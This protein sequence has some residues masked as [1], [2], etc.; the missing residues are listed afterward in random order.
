MIFGESITESFENAISAIV[1][2]WDGFW[3]TLE[4]FWDWLTKA[5]G[6]VFKTLE[7]GWKSIKRVATRV[8]K[9][10]W[11]K[12]EKVIDDVLKAWEG[13][14]TNLG[15]VF[16]NIWTA[17]KKLWDDIVDAAGKV[18]DRIKEAWGDVKKFF[19]D[20]FDGILEPVQTAMQ[21]VYDFVVGLWDDGKGGGIKGAWD[22][23]TGFFKGI[24]ESVKTT[25]LRIW[26][27]IKEK[28]TEAIGPLIA[29]FTKID[30]IASKIWKNSI[31]DDANE[32]VKLMAKYIGEGAGKMNESW[33]EALNSF[34]D[35]GIRQFKKM[36][37][38]TKTYVD[39]QLGI[40]KGFL[41][42]LK[43]AFNKA[44]A[45]MDLSS[46][47]LTA[48]LR[49][50]V[51]D[52]V[53]MVNEVT[54]AF[55]ALRRAQ[56]AVE[57]A[58]AEAIAKSKEEARELKIATAET[59]RIV[60]GDAGHIVNAVNQPDWWRKEAR[61]TFNQ[62]VEILQDVVQSTNNVRSSVDEVK[63]A[64]KQRPIGSTAARK[65][66]ATGNPPTGGFRQNTQ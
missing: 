49:S 34:Y 59:L 17:A 41:D 11:T 3:E 47:D 12:I 31:H 24:W 36:E 40:M 44:F 50:A 42:K 54:R 22:K 39:N 37:K 38:A 21:P 43:E 46:Q 30:E 16:D 9:A 7:K 52:V 26:G 63:T 29:L 4:D 25:A 1:K 10:I 15:R 6:K 2:V 32:S 28:V 65:A 20:L 53:E 57:A 48:D 66:A 8:W 55:R 35:T 60:S 33:G 23:V 56:G 51:D 58:K 61:V 18:W 64:V 62:M 14:K 27:K 13:L 45:E 19:G 5:A